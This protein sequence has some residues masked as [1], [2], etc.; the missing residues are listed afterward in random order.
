[1]TPTR[2]LPG[3]VALLVLSLVGCPTQEENT[4]VAGGP[5]QVVTQV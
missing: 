1:M 3:L 5:C 2:S 4:P